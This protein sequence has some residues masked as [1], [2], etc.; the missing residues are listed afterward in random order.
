MGDRIPHFDFAGSFDAR[1]D[2]THIAGAEFF[3]GHHIHAQDTD[4]VGLV[5]LAGV[6][7]THLIAFAQHAIHDA[8]I[9]D[10]PAIRIEDRVENER[11]QRSFGLAFGRRHALHDGLQNIGHAL[12][13]FAAGRDDVLRFTAD[14]LDDL[15]GDLLHHGIG[16]VYFIHDGDD[17]QPLVQSEVEVGNGLCLNTLGGI[18][19][20][21]GALT[22]S[23]G[24]G[25]FIGEIHV[26]GRVNQ[27]EGIGLSILLAVIIQLYGMALDRDAALALQVHVV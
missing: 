9:G 11:L 7:K 1:D 25:D 14:Q 23:D 4:F 8:E 17:L 3:F 10:D 2:V 15:I 6:Y 27:V 13:R 21:Q 5:F 26:P 24:A 12:P 20:Q 19:Q 16:H 22:G 18:Y